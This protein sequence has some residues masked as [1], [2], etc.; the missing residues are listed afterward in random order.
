MLI[1][2]FVSWFGPEIVLAA[3]GVFLYMVVLYVR[4]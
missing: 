2:A 4:D 1:S 3:I